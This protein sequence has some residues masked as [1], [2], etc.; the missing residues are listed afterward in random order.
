MGQGMDCAAR[1][2]TCARH[3]KCAWC[4]IGVMGVSGDNV[5]WC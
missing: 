5:G 1:L 3:E 2:F 4:L